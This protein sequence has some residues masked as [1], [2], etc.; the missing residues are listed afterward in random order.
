MANLAVRLLGRF[1]AKCG[2]RTLEG[3]LKSQKLPGYLLLCGGRTHSRERPACYGAATG[4]AVEKTK[5]LRRD[6][7]GSKGSE[8]RRTTRRFW[9]A[10]Q[11]RKSDDNK[12]AYAQ[13]HLLRS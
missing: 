6:D 7:G 1:S 2:E 8:P 4:G 11:H 10:V 3:S 9:Q 12:K 5:T 13:G